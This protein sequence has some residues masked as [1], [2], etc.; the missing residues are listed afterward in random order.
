VLPGNVI[1]FAHALDWLHYKHGVRLFRQVLQNGLHLLESAPVL[2]V[3]GLPSSGR[4]SLLRHVDKNRCVALLLNSPALQR[5]EVKVVEDFPPIPGVKVAVHV[6]GG[7][8]KGTGE[9]APYP[10]RGMS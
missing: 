3:T 6:P 1:F 5:G 10:P 7:A 9:V 4:V 8:A 2:K